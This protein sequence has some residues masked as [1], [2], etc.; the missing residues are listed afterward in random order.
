MPMVMLQICPTDLNLNVGVP[1][2][3]ETC[4][5]NVQIIVIIGRALNKEK[6][7]YVLCKI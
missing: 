4:L 1:W 5:R 3:R 7:H 2:S 6:V